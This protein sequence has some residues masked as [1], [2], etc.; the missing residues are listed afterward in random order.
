MAVTGRWP[1]CV[2]ASGHH[3]AVVSGLRAFSD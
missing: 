3:V 2:S 1:T